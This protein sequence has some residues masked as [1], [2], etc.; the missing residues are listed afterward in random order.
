MVKVGGVV[1][2]RGYVYLQVILV[3]RGGRSL[4]KKMDS[5]GK[6]LS[7]TVRSSLNFFIGPPIPGGRSAA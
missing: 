3:R 2:G 5:L 6:G 1:L 7:M 4:L